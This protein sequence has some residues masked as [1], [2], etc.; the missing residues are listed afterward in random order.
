[1]SDK[2]ST[3][4]RNSTTG[5]YTVRVPKSAV[6]GRFVPQSKSTGRIIVKAKPT[7][8]AS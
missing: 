2:K 8:T 6:T 5:S 1:M 3:V 4:G 7:K